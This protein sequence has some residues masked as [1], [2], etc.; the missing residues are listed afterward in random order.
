MILVV[1]TERWNEAFVVMEN[2]CKYGE[3]NN[4]QIVRS[5][6]RKKKYEGK[7]DFLTHEWAKKSKILEVPK[8]LNQLTN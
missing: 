5:I 1:E 2:G 4:C 8:I 6:Y 3:R 7:D